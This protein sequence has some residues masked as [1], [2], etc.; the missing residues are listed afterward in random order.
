MGGVCILVLE[1]RKDLSNRYKGE[2]RI[3][4]TAQVHGMGLTPA[5]GPRLRWIARLLIPVADPR[6]RNIV[7]V[8]TKGCGTSFRFLIGFEYRR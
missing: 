2:S 1:G 3:R 7:V 8:E 4:F 6:D 5:P